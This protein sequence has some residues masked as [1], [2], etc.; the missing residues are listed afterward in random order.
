MIGLISGS[1]PLVLRC[2]QLLGMNRAALI[3][4]A[5]IHPAEFD[6]W[7]RGRPIPAVVHTALWHMVL[8][9][10]IRQKTFVAAARAAL[11]DV[12]K[13]TLFQ[14]IEVGKQMLRPLIRQAVRKARGDIAKW[15][16][17][18]DEVMRG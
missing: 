17:I 11:A 5:G 4:L 6:L 13:E 10:G 16:I 9:L 3:R 18:T 2:L 14:G 1:S 12:D 8:C 7:D 15:K